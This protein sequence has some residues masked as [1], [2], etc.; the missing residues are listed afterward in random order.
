MIKMVNCNHELSLM[1]LREVLFRTTLNVV[2]RNIDKL[3]MYKPSYGL[4][5][6]NIYELLRERVTQN[7]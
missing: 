7:F 4:I 5:C 2:P 3:Q 6:F 1:S